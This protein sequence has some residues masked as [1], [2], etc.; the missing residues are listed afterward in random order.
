MLWICDVTFRI[1]LWLLPWQRALPQSNN[2]SLAR[3][4]PFRPRARATTPRLW[5]NSRSQW[6]M[7]PFQTFRKQSLINT[8]WNALQE[9]P[10]PLSKW[11][12]SRGVSILP[13]KSRIKLYLSILL[14]SAKTSNSSLKQL[15]FMKKLRCM[16]KQLLFISSR[17]T[18]NKPLL[19]WR[20]SKL[21]KF[22]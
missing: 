14:L 2:H 12:I 22:W 9:L 16:R 3:D 7:E 5:S 11:E 15:L 13:E 1:G 6:S 4:W 10:E 17:G 20:K 8:I 21:L 18:L 19:W